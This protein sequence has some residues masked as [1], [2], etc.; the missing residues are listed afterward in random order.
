M[1]SKKVTEKNIELYCNYRYFRDKPI[2]AKFTWS[3]SYENSCKYGILFHSYVS[4]Q[5]F[6]NKIVSSKVYH[7]CHAATT[8]LLSICFQLVQHIQICFHSCVYHSCH[9]SERISQNSLFPLQIIILNVWNKLLL[10][11]IIF[12]GIFELLSYLEGILTGMGRSY[13]VRI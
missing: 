2:F 10:Y 11:I 3:V 9:K 5:S 6:N 8:G 1:P 7:I 13:Y 12:P 4:K